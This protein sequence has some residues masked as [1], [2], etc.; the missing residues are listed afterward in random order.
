M[1]TK[2][3]NECCVLLATGGVLHDSIF[4]WTGRDAMETVHASEFVLCLLGVMKSS[5]TSKFLLRISLD[6]GVCADLCLCKKFDVG[7]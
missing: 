6:L 3:G 7:N 4:F 1:S 5:S 2:T